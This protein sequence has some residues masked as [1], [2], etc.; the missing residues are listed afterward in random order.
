[1]F[2]LR[3]CKR[4]LLFEVISLLNVSE[5]SLRCPHDIKLGLIRKVVPNYRTSSDNISS[6]LETSPTSKTKYSNVLTFKYLRKLIALI[7]EIKVRN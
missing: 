6:L 4:G 2:K 1:M 5:I 7:C 3:I